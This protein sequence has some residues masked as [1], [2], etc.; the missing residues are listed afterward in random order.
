MAAAALVNRI[1]K[2]VKGKPKA[3]SGPA[4]GNG[5]GAAT[6]SGG[7]KVK[8]DRDWVWVHFPDKPSEEIRDAL[9][10]LGGRWSRKRQAW[11]FTSSTMAQVEAVVM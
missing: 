7:V 5:N 9:K 8:Q 4:A 2:A 10:G 11:Y 1:E 3:K 6:S